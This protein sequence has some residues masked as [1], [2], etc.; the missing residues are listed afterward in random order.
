MC[1]CVSL[2]LSSFEAGHA[3]VN[4]LTHG[5]EPWLFLIVIEKKQNEMK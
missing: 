1:V 2:S 4:V 5:I 3:N